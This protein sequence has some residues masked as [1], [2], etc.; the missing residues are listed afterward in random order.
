MLVINKT[1][2]P[3]NAGIQFL[4]LASLKNNQIRKLDPGLR[5]DDDRF[6]G[7]FGIFHRL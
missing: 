1:V 7:R 6:R 4:P 5:R 3:A 2:I